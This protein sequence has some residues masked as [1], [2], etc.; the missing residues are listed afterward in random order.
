M[1]LKTRGCRET[2]DMW[3]LRLLTFFDIYS[4]EF[5]RPPAKRNC[6]PREAGVARRTN[7]GCSQKCA[8]D[9]TVLFLYSS[10]GNPVVLWFQLPGEFM[11]LAAVLC[12]NCAPIHVGSLVRAY[13]CKRRR[14]VVAR[15]K[16]PDRAL[17]CATQMLTALNRPFLLHPQ[18]SSTFPLWAVSGP[19]QA[20]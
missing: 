10:L 11:V 17:T 18:R 15:A 19:E 4:C 8:S 6:S 9:P 5:V 20:V 7:S 16:C 14:P 1:P 3:L 13:I 2:V 12:P